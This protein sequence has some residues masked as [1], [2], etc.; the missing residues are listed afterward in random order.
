VLSDVNES[1]E[2]VEGDGLIVLERATVSFA[3]RAAFAG[4]VCGGDV[5][6]QTERK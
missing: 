3:P 5:T 4:S 2:R 6:Y 1:L